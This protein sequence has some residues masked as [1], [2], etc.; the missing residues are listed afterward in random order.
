MKLKVTAHDPSELEAWDRYAA[1]ALVVALG[2]LER[3]APD[4]DP[5]VMAAEAADALLEQR[6]LRRS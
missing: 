4:S 6:R 5:A 3:H 2:A 1:A